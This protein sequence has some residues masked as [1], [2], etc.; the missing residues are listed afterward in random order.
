MSQ[1]TAFIVSYIF[2]LIFIQF[3][4]HCI[5]VVF[6]FAIHFNVFI[7][8]KLITCVTEKPSL[9]SVSKV[10]IV[11]I[12]FELR[13]ALLSE[14]ASYNLTTL[15]KYCVTVDYLGYS[16]IYSRSVAQH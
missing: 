13:G 4:Y 3:I 16:N 15:H 7:I 11:F 8:C 14:S 9:G 5:I 1:I 12:V 6:R 2:S 10:C